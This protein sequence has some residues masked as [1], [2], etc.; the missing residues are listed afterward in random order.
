MMF[1]RLAAP[2]FISS[3]LVIPLVVLQWMNRRAFHEDFPFVL[4]AFMS[5]HAL[6]IVLLVTPA[7]RQLQLERR[8]GALKFHHWAGLAVAA[9]LISVYAEVVVDQLPC[10]LG[11]PNCD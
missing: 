11:V 6:F 9:V 2:V 8:L 10:F 5:V 7:L 3:T 4:F 1:W